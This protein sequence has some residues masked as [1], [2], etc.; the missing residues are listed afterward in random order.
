[1]TASIDPQS[2]DQQQRALVTQFR[3]APLF[4]VRD[5]GY[6]L[7]AV[8]ASGPDDRFGDTADVTGAGAGPARCHQSHED[9]W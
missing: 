3:A 6:C 2:V 7:R 1:L 5:L 8:D 9:P 4:S